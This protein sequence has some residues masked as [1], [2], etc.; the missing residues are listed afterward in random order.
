MTNDQNA[1]RGRHLDSLAADAKRYVL[2]EILDVTNAVAAELNDLTLADFTGA[3]LSTAG[4]SGLVPA[5]SIGDED[6][7]LR[8][9][10]TWASVLGGAYE[11][12]TA[13]PNQK[14]TT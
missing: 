9:D 10:G 6:K 7:F 8:G 1:V 4:L 14:S 12:P 2:E 5:P 3:G 11:L 13:S